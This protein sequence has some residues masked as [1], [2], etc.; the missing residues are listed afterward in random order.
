[1]SLAL[2]ELKAVYNAKKAFIIS[3]MSLYRNGVTAVIEKKLD[4][5]SVQHFCFFNINTAP[6]ISLI[7]E[8][9]KAVKLF[10]PDVIISFGSG[11]AADTAKLVRVKY[12]Y[13][14]TDLCVL[15]SDFSDIA[16]R[17]K[18]FPKLGEK[19]L[20]VSIA[21]INSNASE[22]SPYAV[23]YADGEELYIADYEIMSDMAV[24]DADF[25]LD[26]T[27]EEIVKAGLSALVRAVNALDSQTATEYTDGFVIKAV[28][29][30]MQYM[31]EAVEKGAK[32]SKSFEKLI[33]A[34]N[35]AAI[36]YANTSSIINVDGTAQYLADIIRLS[37][38]ESEESCS[39]YSELSSAL[40]FKGNDDKKLT[41][42][43]IG[44]IEELV[45]FCG[46]ENKA[47]KCE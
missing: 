45:S 13:P 44:K 11:Y 29:G 38:A 24:I 3:D 41:E 43:L 36:A 12:E 19:A 1:M 37:A 25:M 34:L 23:F 39:R 47:L 2:D 5:L 42:K 20:L 26:G 40:G 16:Y 7:E 33:E 10:E 22:V 9:A 31:P 27:K 21:D 14:E 46:L 28:Q 17:E 35:M 32:E 6:D 15:S 4:E 8:A 18:N 30:I